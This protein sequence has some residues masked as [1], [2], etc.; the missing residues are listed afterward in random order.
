MMKIFSNPRLTI[1][2]CLIF[3]KA[4]VKRISKDTLIPLGMVGAIVAASITLNN[5]LRDLQTEVAGIKK[6]LGT[7]WTIHDMQNWEYQT[8]LENPTFKS[9]SVRDIVA[10]RPEK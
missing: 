10:A 5:S 3:L 7:A 4:D 2:A 9:P 6:F 1:R 8:R